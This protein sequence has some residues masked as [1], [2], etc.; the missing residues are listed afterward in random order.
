MNT[1][2][3]YIQEEAEARRRRWEILGTFYVAVFMIACLLLL[4]D[5][6]WPFL[7]EKA[8][9]IIGSCVGLVFAGGVLL[10][11]VWDIVGLKRR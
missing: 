8:Y 1:Q 10:K 9:F 5:T 6:I 2:D 7:P 11:F 4:A 3:D